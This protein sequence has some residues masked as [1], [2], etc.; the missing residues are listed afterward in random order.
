MAIKIQVQNIA[1][2]T[3]HKVRCPNDVQLK[4]YQ[5]VSLHDTGFESQLDT[6]D[7]FGVGVTVAVW[8]AVEV[9]VA[10]VGT[11]VSLDATAVLF[12]GACVLRTVGTAV[13][14]AGACV[15][16]TVGTAVLF[17]GACVLRTVGNGDFFSIVGVAVGKTNVLVGVP[18]GGVGLG[19]TSVL[20]N[21]VDVFG[22]GGTGVAVGVFVGGTE[23]FVGVSVGG[24]GVSVGNGVS[25]GGTEVAVGASVGGAG[26]FVGVLVSS[27]VGVD[28]SVGGTEVSVGGTG[29]GVGVC[30]SE[31]LVG[32]GV[33]CG[34]EV[35]V[36]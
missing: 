17:A 16:G 7:R 19:G 3:C 31:R 28:V 9:D 34:A 8:L 24:T 32:V 11:C 2:F 15:V 18:N 21:G 13:L 30:S 36:G 4:R 25:V 27:G 26:V 23:V 20:G 1:V 6:G 12:A 35:G 29:V 33:F 14:F 22:F 10:F 5:S